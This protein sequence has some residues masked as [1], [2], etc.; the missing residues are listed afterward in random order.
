MAANVINF[1]TAAMSMIKARPFGNPPVEYRKIEDAI[2]LKKNDGNGAFG[3]INF[4][5][6]LGT[7]FTALG[8]GT[9]FAGLY[10]D[11]SFQK[12]RFTTSGIVSSAVGLIALA[13]GIF[14]KDP[15]VDEM[16]KLFD[17]QVT[18]KSTSSND[19]A[20]KLTATFDD[21]VQNKQHLDEFEIIFSQIDERGTTVNL[22][23]E[24]GTGKT[25]GID[26]LCGELAKKKGKVVEHWEVSKD[27]TG[28]SFGD[29]LSKIPLVGGMVGETRAQRLER[30]VS[31][32]IAEVR[33][34]YDA[35]GNPTKYIVI[36]VDEVADWLGI[37]EDKW[38]RYGFN[39]DD[40]MKRSEIS[41]ALGVIY[42]KLR[43]EQAKGVVVA[44]MSNAINKDVSKHLKDRFDVNQEY[45]CPEASLRKDYYLKVLNKL[46][47]EKGLNFQL[48][49][50]ECVEL[51]NVGDSNLLL[52]IFGTKDY[53]D[54][55]RIKEGDVPY[56]YRDG[57][58]SINEMQNYHL[59]NFR[60]IR[61]QC[62]EPLLTQFA[63]NNLGKGEFIKQLTEKL[64]N[65][66]QTKL[67]TEKSW[68]TDLDRRV[69]YS[70]NR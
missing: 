64:N 61:K 24:V 23:G 46:I 5:H 26:C 29:A 17:T 41:N 21:Y 43:A 44:T 22:M 1:S 27:A 52:D 3:W 30:I 36:S 35:S 39:A 54:E 55:T 45:R 19:P 66:T 60:N 65:I 10:G 40:P 2:A 58:I 59:I 62:V 8:V 49:E 56:E 47:S 31:N 13:T 57:G 18:K 70:R 67:R 25:Y 12:I 7:L 48:S 16:K 69:G 38:E 32:A 63:S 28:S 37:P 14:G 6:I 9:L 4:G 34:S 68:Q 11:T 53:N 42:N 15:S 33:K 51:A 20:L 50:L